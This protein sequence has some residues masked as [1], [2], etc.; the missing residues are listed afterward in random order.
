MLDIMPLLNSCQEFAT[1][2]KQICTEVMIGHIRSIFYLVWI[3]N[4]LD[5][6]LIDVLYCNSSYI[7]ALGNSILT[8]VAEGHELSCMILF[9]Q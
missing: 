9:W 2:K 6:V 4:R 1:S 5:T 8:I 3:C 7:L